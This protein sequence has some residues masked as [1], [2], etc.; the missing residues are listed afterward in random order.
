METTDRYKSLDIL[1]KDIRVSVSQLKD[2][3]TSQKTI[4]N[5]K[6]EVLHFPRATSAN[7]ISSSQVMT[8][9]SAKISTLAEQIGAT[10]SDQMLL[11]SL[12]FTSIKDRQDRVAQSYEKTFEWVLDPASPTKFED[13]LRH[14]NGVYYITGKPGSGKS[15]LMKYLMNHPDIPAIIKAWAGVNKPITASFFFWNAGTAV[16]KSQEGLFRSLLYEILRQCPD[17]IRTVCASKAETFR[18]YANELAPWTQQELRHAIRQLQQFSGSGVR[19]C[20][21]ID[22]LDEYDG[23]PDR[24]VEILESLRTWQDIKLCVS[25]RPWNEFK[26]AFG[27]PNDPTLAM[28]DLTREDISVYVRET[29]EESSSFRRLQE[30]DSRSQSLVQEIFEKAR[31]VFLWVVLVV[32]SLLTGLR[33]EDRIIDLQL[34]LREFPETL[35]KY[36]SHMLGSIEPV[37]RK[38]TAQTFKIALEAIEPLSLLTYYLLDEEDLG[39]PLESTDP[40]FSSAGLDQRCY[41]MRRRLNGRY[42]GLLEVVDSG[43]SRR[44][45]RTLKVDFLHRTVYDFLRTKDMQNLLDAN[46]SL[47]SEP[48]ALMCKALFAQMK[49]I[50]LTTSPNSREMRE[51]LDDLVY[52]AGKLEVASDTPQTGLMDD[53]AKFVCKHERLFNLESE[54]ECCFFEFIVHRGLCLYLVEVLTRKP[55]MRLALKTL[56]LRSALDSPKTKYSSDNYHPKIVQILLAHGASPNSRY[57]D[58]TVWGSFLQSLHRSS[59]TAP[60][61]DLK[62]IIELLLRHDPDRRHQVVTGQKTASARRS[63]NLHRRMSETVEDEHSSAVSI[64]RHV[65]GYETDEILRKTQNAESQTEPL[66]PRPQ[67]SF[68]V[69]RFRSSKFF[70]R[71]TVL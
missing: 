33:N 16:Q 30:R 26:D 63:G 67:T 3:T 23:E 37:Y 69:P 8:D 31:G 53:V 1:A 61:D 25:S 54:G 13:W 11:D 21:F 64:L 45:W 17:M 18:P 9:L 24:L 70:K 20:I 7:A 40:Q 56:L 14:E 59:I 35:E 29:L 57:M 49:L 65:L 41:I 44:D 66:I 6:L 22:G 42:K 55:P 68:L 47:G 43:S 39:A 58:D 28:E 62:Q 19:F 46:L 2:A 15:T 52:Y 51:L 5:K 12:W 48:K 32:R 36:F 50:E 38:H 4:V 27:R 34:R 60:G 10:A 71:L